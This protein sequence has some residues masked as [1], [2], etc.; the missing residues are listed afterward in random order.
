[1]KCLWLLLLCSCATTSI[2]DLYA[3]RAACLANGDVCPE[4]HK[5]ID[6]REAR[7]LKREE[8]R[9]RK[10]PS[11]YVELVNQWGHSSCVPASEIYR[12]IGGY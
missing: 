12:V 10:C 11:R 4:V 8:A 9:A 1:M 6:R 3:Q 2:D 5:Q 7:A